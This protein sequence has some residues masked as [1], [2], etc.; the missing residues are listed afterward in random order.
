[1]AITDDATVGMRVWRGDDDSLE[2][3]ATIVQAFDERGN[4]IAETEL[5]VSKVAGLEGDVAI[6][7]GTEGV[8]TL[9]ATSHIDRR[10]V[11]VR[12]TAPVETGA[13]IAAYR[14]ERQ[15]SP[16]HAYELGPLRVPE[17]STA[18]EELDPRI[19]EGACTPELTCTLS[20][21]VGARSARVRV[22]P[23]VGVVL[24]GSDVRTGRGFLRFPLIVRGNEARIE[25]V[26]LDSDDRP[27]ASRWVRLPL[28]MGG[29]RAAAHVEGASVRLEWETLGAARP[30]LVDVYRSNQ[31]VHAS[32]V[33]VDDP[34]LP[35]S[36]APGVWRLQ[37][38]TDPFSED[39]AAVIHVAIADSLFEALELAAEDVL[40]DG[41]SD[42][43][44]PLAVAVREGRI[45]VSES[46]AALAALFGP[47]NFG[48]V[49][50]S[51]VISSLADEP[52]P[53]RRDWAR[54]LAAAAIVGIGALVSSMLL[55]LEFATRRRAREVLEGFEDGLPASPR[56]APLESWLWAFV[57][58]VFLAIAAIAL[59]KGWF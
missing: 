59:S 32:S 23:E 29:V 16:F 43:L 33:T 47:R 3:P 40:A 25:V 1:M 38:R 41:G 9:L 6:P 14:P 18:P 24:E 42:G 56:R 5:R 30:I 2:A 55:R 22:E 28:A 21:W 27:L 4:I 15:T 37:L 49:S 51:G 8:V 10:T 44:D 58:A 31:W 7:S 50:S 26:A 17:P 34:W 12:Y 39:T 11:Q 20:V 53:S 19:E 45:P 48:V 13:S 57:L 46:E 54:W 36:L 35:L 52:D